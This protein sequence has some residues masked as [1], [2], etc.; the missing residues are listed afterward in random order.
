M[1]VAEM[2][3]ARPP[4]VE[5]SLR[6][7]E[8]RAA[9]IALNDGGLVMKDEAW[10]TVCQAGGKDSTE[11]PAEQWLAQ[12]EQESRYWPKK[13]P[14]KWVKGF[15]DVYKDWKNGVTGNV[16]GTSVRHVSIY[17]PAEVANLLRINIGSVEDAAA[18]SGEAL[19]HYGLGGVLVK[20]KAQDWVQS[21]DA[22]QTALELTN[23]REQN[24]S[25]QAQIQAQADSMREQGETLKELTAQ[26]GV[27]NRSKKAG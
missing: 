19:K 17:T 3:D 12:M 1:S 15:R 7:V 20:Q 26:L 6:P 13:M 21:K 2:K 22:N 16:N 23:L 11:F 14:A 5:F 27:L 24:Q 8:D 25:L 9:T 4:H 18:M 10:V